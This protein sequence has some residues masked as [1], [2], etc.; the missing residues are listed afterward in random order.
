MIRF[1]GSLWFRRILPGV[2]LV[3]SV[4]ASAQN[5]STEQ[6]RKEY[7]EK[8]QQILPPDPYFNT[9][10]QKTNALP[11]DFEALP[12]QNQL[13]DPLTFLDGRRV[14][15]A[16]G[17]A[18]RRNEIDQ[19]SQ[20]YVWGTIPPKP[21][22]D[23]VVVLDEKHENGYL[24]RNVRLVFGPEDKGSMRARVVIPDG[25]EPMPVLLNCDLLGWAPELIRRGYIS[26]GYAGN[27]MMDDA[28]ALDKLYPD[29]D[30]A[31]LPR[32]AWA[33][34][35]VLDYLET[36]PQ[37]DAK[38]IA[39]FGYSR[40]GKMATIAAALDTRFAAVIAGSTGVGGVLPWRASGEVGIGEGIEATTR[41]FPT[42]FAP[43][44]RFFTGREDRL[45]VDGNL[46]AAMIAP[47]SLLME[48]GNN[49]QVSNT[50]GNEQ[51]YYSALKVYQLLGVPD[52]ISTMRVPGFHGANDEEACLDWLDIQFGRSKATWTNNLIFRWNWDQWRSDTNQSVSLSSFPKHN[53][54]D[55]ASV[56]TSAEWEAKSAE[57]HKSVEWML[58][59][60][61]P[62]MTEEEINA[63]RFHFRPMPPGAANPG[64]VTPDLPAWAISMQARGDNEYGWTEPQR[65]KTVSRRLTF[66]DN[67][68]GDLYYPAGTP[69]GTKLPVV[70][71]LHGYSYP[72]GYMWGYHEDTH[73]ILA[74]V[75]AGYAVFAYDQ[76]GF[77][78][79]LGE[80]G[81]FYGRYPQ[82]S[83]MGRLVE[84]AQSAIDMLQK[85]SMIDPQRVYL[86]GYSLGGTVAVYTAAL[87]SR[88]KGIV[89]VAG[90]T[91]MRTDTA[92][93]GTGGVARYSKIRDFIPR[94][95]FFDGHESQIPYDFN[96]LL[97]MIAPRPALIVQ[98]L[99]DR[100]ATPADVKTA[101][102][103]AGKIYSLYDAGAKLALREP[104]DI[105]RLPNNTLN[106]TVQWM[107]LNEK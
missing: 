56:H 83:H 70:I 13:P 80:T 4:C 61:P 1:E 37:V 59:T 38:H 81:P 51:T 22:L 30:F 7:L 72:L 95:G 8:L 26:A 66:S 24:V 107:S 41:R 2:L 15:T 87:D 103:Q 85:D 84:D 36:L 58:G 57:L 90:F 29:Y 17:W 105:N 6:G 27:D 16:G 3:A 45:P 86:Y 102:E 77:G 25:K 75:Q 33:A 91:P 73:P 93:T 96:D 39:I 104:W 99:L 47:R 89:S 46:V 98:P 43:Q 60:E 42:W 67:L 82:W 40:N 69:D 5:T 62:K 63:G 18:A 32:R 94:L 79:R 49:D 35:L 44:L 10:L 100:D 19:L 48:W 65:S 76:S 34:S 54:D 64:Q 101:V 68:R 11:P 14:T 88:V 97:A 71:W 31:L 20:K 53:G 12:K 106:E 78:S 23:H 9:W 52:R 55:L 92:A 74:L 28:A 21:K 50:W